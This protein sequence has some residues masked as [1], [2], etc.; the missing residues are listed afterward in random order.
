L[1]D[2][3]GVAWRPSSPDGRI[4][5]AVVSAVVEDS[6]EAGQ[7][8]VFIARPG[9]RTD[10][11]RFIAEALA[12]GASAVALPVGSPVPAGVPAVFLD[13]IAVG[14]AR[15]AEAACAWP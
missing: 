9:T 3:A 1:F 5:Q 2:R 14:A 11:A 15:L 7:G 12:R 10:G 8:S 13:D 6:R 4:A